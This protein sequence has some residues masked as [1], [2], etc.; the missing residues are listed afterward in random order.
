MSKSALVVTINSKSGAEALTLQKNVIVLGD[1]FYTK[2]PLVN[3]LRDLSKLSEAITENLNKIPADKDCIYRYF[4]SVWSKSYS[5]DLYQLD[6]SNV[7]LFSEVIE[8]L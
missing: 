3:E 4:S 5:G 2:S 1:A 6:E 8:R 7:K